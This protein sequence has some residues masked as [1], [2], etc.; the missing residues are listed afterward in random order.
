MVDSNKFDYIKVA[1]LSIDFTSIETLIYEHVLLTKS[2]IENQGQINEEKAE[3]ISITYDEIRDYLVT[4][5]LIENM[6]LLVSIFR[7][8]LMK[9]LR[10]N[11]Q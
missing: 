9:L 6:N 7:I 3:T 2:I 10:I 11:Y 4:N 5:L 8:I 1:E